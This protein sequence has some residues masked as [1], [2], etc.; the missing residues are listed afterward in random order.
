MT[1]LCWPEGVEAADRETWLKEDDFRRLFAG[2]GW[3]EYC[4]LPGWRKARLKQ[5]AG[6]F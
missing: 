1:G 4:K 2:L 6:L 3:E 5:D